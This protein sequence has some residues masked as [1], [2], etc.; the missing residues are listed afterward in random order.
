[1]WPGE[2]K[3]D[4]AQLASQLS[5]QAR[6]DV[7][8][9]TVEGLEDLDCARLVRSFPRLRH[10]TLRGKLGRVENAGDL[11]ALTSL[12][13]LAVSDLF[14]MTKED[15][16]LPSSVPELEWLALNSVPREYGAAMR[17]AW[18]K[19]VGKGLLADAGNDAMRWSG[20]RDT[21]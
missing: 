7:W 3:V 8:S 16:L 2:V 13:H 15:C 12:K 17:P 5:D 1:V 4:G 18:V 14:G 10:L 20:G 19:E 6:E 9:V 21:I 11:N